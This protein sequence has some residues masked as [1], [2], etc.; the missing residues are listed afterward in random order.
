MNTLKQD[1]KQYS[2]AVFGLSA[3]RDD[4][5]RRTNSVVKQSLLFYL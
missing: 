1:Q 4:D 5:Y 3:A 2:K